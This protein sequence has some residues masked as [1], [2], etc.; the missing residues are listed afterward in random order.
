MSKDLAI[1]GVMVVSCLVVSVAAFVP[2][3]DTAK[4]NTALASTGGAKPVAPIRQ[5]TAPPD[6]LPLAP[7]AG[8]RT[9]DPLAGLPPFDT[10]NGGRTPAAP[11]SPLPDA[12]PIP[13]PPAKPPT[14]GALI[15]P[16]APAIDPSTPKTHV[17]AKGEYLGDISLKHYGTSKKWQKIKD[18]N[19]G[20]DENSLQ[21]GQKLVIPADTASKTA[22]SATGATN[23]PVADA[24]SGERTYT[25]RERDSY[26]VIAQRELGD[27]N[28]WKE[29]EGLNKTASEDL[30]VGQ[31]IKLPAR[32]EAAGV[33]ATAPGKLPAAN[34]DDGRKRH[35][36]GEGE[37]LGSISQKYYSTSKR[38]QDIERAN[39]GIDPERL[40]VGQKIIIPDVK[41]DAAVP[42]KP[43]A[44]PASGDVSEYAVK[45]ED[46]LTSIADRFYKDGGRANVDRILKANPGVDPNRLRVGQKL[47][48]PGVAPTAPKADA[49][50]APEKI[51]KKDPA[52]PFA[53]RAPAAGANPF[54][55]AAPNPSPA[56]PPRATPPAAPA[57]AANPNPF[58]PAPGAV[59]PPTTPPVT[60]APAPTP[61]PAA[62]RNNDPFA[63]LPKGKDDPF[64]LDD[65]FA[66]EPPVSGQ[67][68]PGDAPAAPAP[69]DPFQGNDFFR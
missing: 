31:V 38:W 33:V 54:A 41:A 53:P 12:L 1:A 11:F 64:A 49:P 21:V 18:A 63:P 9:N 61:P 55:P 28:R 8:P 52:N 5:P 68:E 24:A 58:A 50:K 27:A 22:T 67:S 34:D 69:R 20:L 14:V 23:A 6:A 13:V 46:T 66:P 44:E 19:P 37:T 45:A 16:P 65:P 48:I 60:A 59:R 3:K 47:K 42:A 43:A 40:Y 15:D 2:P 17:V 7:D 35:V 30:R 62:P 39:P 57:P 29:L 10:G 51:E 32:K 26:Y 4:P 56:V 36:V 25:I